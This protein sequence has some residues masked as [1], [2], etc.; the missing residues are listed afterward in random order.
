MAVQIGAKKLAGFDQPLEML[1]DCH[2]R[3]EHFLDVMLRVEEIYRHQALD[4]QAKQALAV[5]EEYFCKAAV[6]HTADEESSLFP[7]MRMALPDHHPAISAIEGLIAE[8]QIAEK[9]HA[10]IQ[11]LFDQWRLSADRLPRE[12]AA[13]L[14]SELLQIRQH[15]AQHILVEEQQVFPVAGTVLNSEQKAMIGKEMHARRQ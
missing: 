2:R 9:L 13:I 12:Q 4:D 10:S 3:V 11:Q 1:A 5:C 7:R 14:R 15:Y 8:H 6:K